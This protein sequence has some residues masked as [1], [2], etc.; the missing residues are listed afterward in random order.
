MLYQTTA[1][2]LEEQDPPDGA[3]TV[4]PTFPDAAAGL[5]S[6]APDL[7]VFARMLLHGGDGVLEPATAAAM[8]RDQLTE[9]QRALGGLGPGFF[10]HQ[11]W[12]F[13]QAVGD[14]GSFGWDGGLG[15][16]WRVEPSTGLIVMTLT[17]VQWASPQPTALLTEVVATARAALA[18]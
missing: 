12:G 11:S 15:T 9:A 17:Q 14:D 8:C 3:W 1:N 6:T 2:G 18:E 7:L 13:C 10:D 5:I 16:A 4:M